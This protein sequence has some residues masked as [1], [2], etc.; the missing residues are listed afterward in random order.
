MSSQANRR[1]NHTR[2]KIRSQVRSFGAWMMALVV[3]SLGGC[4]YTGGVKDY[5]HNGFKVGPE[6]CKPAAPVSDEWIDAYEAQVCAELPNYA[7][8]WTVFNDP[9]LNA[10]MEEAYQQNLSL[11]QAGLRVMQARYIRAIAIG[12]WFPQQQQAVGSYSRNLNSQ[13]V[14]AGMLP[15]T[16]DL[17]KVG[18]D[19]FWELDTWGKFRRNIESADASLDASV[20]DY[21]A[22]LVSLLGETATAY[23]DLRTAQQRLRFA[24]ENAKIQAGSLKLANDRVEAGAVTRLDSTQAQTVLANTQQ[25]IPL[26]ENQIRAANNSL[27]VLLGIPPRDLIPELG[28]GPI[29]S[30]PA[31][32]VVGVPANLLRRRPDVRAAERR[33]AAQSAAIGVAAADLLPHFSIVGSM[34]LDAEKFSELFTSASSAGTISPGFNWDIL[35]YGR[36]INNVNLQ[37]AAF[38][39]LAVEYQQTVLE[40]AA[41]VENSI[42]TFLKSKER[43]EYVARAVEASKE[44]VELADTQ[45]KTGAVDYNR[46]FNLQTVLVADQDNLAFVQGEAARSVVATYKALGGGWEVRYGIRR[47]APPAPTEE[48]PAPQQPDVLQDGEPIIPVPLDEPM[49]LPEDKLGG[50]DDLGKGLEQPVAPGTEP[51]RLPN[52]PKDELPELQVDDI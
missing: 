24:K 51:R 11:K 1:S 32:I 30:L 15:R 26:Y 10:L 4:A 25:L 16:Q 50:N 6:Y 8:W 41:E 40:A 44:S 47:G 42:N 18:F 14:V 17:W 3:V 48:V 36:L 27:C 52:V 39:E 29:P 12:S 7:D 19:A 22:V 20:E 37:D 34:R 9:V 23:I 45:Y 13:N 46:V 43:L 28:E 33:A 38:Q 31:D 5:I 2:T 21:D 49:D 35:N